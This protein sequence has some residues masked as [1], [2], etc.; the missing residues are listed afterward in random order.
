MQRDPK[1]LAKLLLSIGFVKDENRINSYSF[2][3]DVEAALDKPWLINRWVITSSHG[4]WE[5]EQIDICTA[6]ETL[7]NRL[8]QAFKAVYGPSTKLELIPALN[9]GV[10]VLVELLQTQP[11]Q[12]EFPNGTIGFHFNLTSEGDSLCLHFSKHFIIG[13]APPHFLVETSFIF[14]KCLNFTHEKITY[15]RG[16]F[17]SRVDFVDFLLHNIDRHDKLSKL[18]EQAVDL[19]NSLKEGIKTH[20]KSRFNGRHWQITATNLDSSLFEFDVPPIEIVESR[21]LGIKFHKIDG[22]ILNNKISE[23]KQLCHA[24]L[25]E[26]GDSL[27][28]LRR[29]SIIALAEEKPISESLLS[30]ML[31]IDSENLLFLSIA[32]YSAMKENR[33]K[34]QLKYL[35]K[36]G[37]LLN[38]ELTNFDELQ[39]MDMVLPELLGDGWAPVDL[40]TA[41]TCYQRVVQKRG[42]VPRVLRKLV[43]IA[44]ERQDINGEIQL[45]SRL[46]EVDT[47]K[48]L[49]AENYMRLANLY[50]SNDIRLAAENALSAW[51]LDP[52]N[53]NYAEFAA[54]GLVQSK[55]F[56][57]AVR[58]LDDCRKF[59]D[60]V[61]DNQ[62]KINLELAI[63]RIWFTF[64]K[65][66]DLA[67][68]RIEHA[69]LLMPDDLENLKRCEDISLEFGEESLL[70][71][72]RQRIFHQALR[73]RNKTEVFRVVDHLLKHYKTQ[74]NMDAQIVKIYEK[75]IQHYL[76]SHEEL[77][78]L[79]SLKKV[80]I[81][82]TRLVENI[83]NHVDAEKDI[84]KQPYLIFV[85]EVSQLKLENK[86]LAAE[87]FE[88]A[89]DLGKIEP[90]IYEFLNEYYA[91]INKP[92]LRDKVLKHQL[93]N[94][95]S[96][97]RV[98]ILKDLFYTSKSLS[99]RELDSY[100]TM[101]LKEGKE[102]AALKKRFITYQ[103]RADVK[104][105]DRLYNE[106]L[107]EISERVEQFKWMLYTQSIL[108][109]CDSKDRFE[110][111]E[112]VLQKMKPHYK[113]IFEWYEAG[114]K[115]HQ[116][117]PDYKYLEPYL[118]KLILNGIPPKID[119]HITLKVL[120]SNPIAKGL[121][122]RY[123]ADQEKDF[124]RIAENL[125]NSLQ[126]LA[127]KAGY[128]HT[129]ENILEQLSGMVVL[130]KNELETYRQLTEKSEKIEN[131]YKV[132]GSQLE[133]VINS[134]Q[135]NQL[136]DLS[137]EII[138]DNPLVKL[139]FAK[140]MLKCIEAFEP[141]NI[142][143]FRFLLLE[144]NSEYRSFMPEVWGKM[145]LRDLNNWKND[146]RYTMILDWI[147]EDPRNRDTISS[148]FKENMIKLRTKRDCEQLD[149]YSLLARTYG[150]S[151]NTYNWFLFQHF[152][153]VPEPEKSSYYWVEYLRNIKEISSW[154]KFW[155]DS[156]DLLGA[157]SDELYH[158][159]RIAY[160][161][162]IQTAHP[163]VYDEL[164]FEYGNFLFLN[165]K[166]PELAFKL[167]NER[168]T[169]KPDDY[170]TWL[171]L[172]FL[173]SILRHSKEQYEL[174]RFILPKIDDHP[175]LIGNYPIT[176]ESLYKD[177]VNVAKQLK[178]SAEI[179]SF[180][181]DPSKPK[182]PNIKKSEFGH[183]K[184]E[185]TTTKYL[186]DEQESRDKDP[187]TAGKPVNLG[188]LFA[189]SAIELSRDKQKEP[190]PL[191]KSVVS[192]VN[193]D[194]GS[195]DKVNHEQADKV[196]PPVQKVD[197]TKPA[198]P[199]T[200]TES[201]VILNHPETP[202]AIPKLDT[203]GV[204][205][206]TEISPPRATLPDDP[207]KIP[208][209]K[210]GKK[211]KKS[212]LN[213]KKARWPFG[214]KAPETPPS[215]KSVPKTPSSQGRMTESTA[216]SLAGQ[217]TTA[218]WRN[219]LLASKGEKLIPKIQGMG[220]A[221]RVEKY[222][223]LQA[224]SLHDG[225]T[226]E[227]LDHF[228]W[229]DFVE[230]WDGQWSNIKLD[231][232]DSDI[233]R[234]LGASRD[235]LSEFY[236]EKYNLRTI[237]RVFG[238]SIDK[239]LAS[240]TT[241]KF[242]DLFS[243]P[244]AENYQKFLQDMDV[245]IVFVDGPEK[246][247]YEARKGKLYVGQSLAMSPNP[248][249]LHHILYI[250][251]SVQLGLFE[252][253]M[254]KERLKDPLITFLKSSRF[255]LQEKKVIDKAIAEFEKPG[256]FTELVQR[257]REQVLNILLLETKNLID[258]AQFE[259][260][261]DG[262]GEGV[263]SVQVR[264]YLSLIVKMF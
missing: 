262:V 146:Q 188:S 241:A 39:T 230:P 168:Y 60:S 58:V 263:S 214:S 44:R 43:S 91:S 45:L 258:L 212:F 259:A 247:L 122:Y 42:D 6:I 9:Y 92:D 89:V 197:P 255:E 243:W 178:K 231:I 141:Q 111:I 68:L 198:A 166:E 118:N 144:I 207:D 67:K 260:K 61:A 47:D 115:S 113:D 51:K 228:N 239:F 70:V 220:F 169:R 71:D 100:G 114:V 170:H 171:P 163:M 52:T 74:A 191:P 41:Q 93:R 136:K 165:D 189:N 145:Y 37:Q 104:S 27:F 190:R 1:N 233:Y 35:S 186:G 210:V 140:N 62:K 185:A 245:E 23:A 46:V 48:N 7:G 10:W 246:V 124:D 79:L 5:T 143:E 76:I 223:A 199:P 26:E 97:Q 19:G 66:K 33:T 4:K 224:A 219:C 222:L 152:H 237:S 226:A 132:I 56:E 102:D 225:E 203:Q 208:T 75:L 31:S 134:D 17:E 139:D 234:A 81:D 8:D 94:A 82:W 78:G 196:P 54:Y 257:S 175:E 55:D 21:E 195:Q 123:L 254:L 87:Y 213:L 49:V 103:E 95:N 236:Q 202:P 36:M 157:D 15:K 261:M 107:N 85:G 240:R 135:F 235:F 154:K 63:A 153:T 229:L 176:T 227:V 164:C 77:Y 40:Q 105:I 133:H 130:Q 142:V 187:K 50:Q 125:R 205:E 32:S 18:R 147:L 98:P 25:E 217:Q 84:D 173:N 80:S 138:R 22:L 206:N 128:E 121:Y 215:P 53:T 73:I 129:T 252:V 160:R 99:D 131:F 16:I 242:T 204:R 251:R 110:L 194:R 183:T 24:A 38:E 127:G 221:N 209:V 172:Y 137:F 148:I 256:C 30:R 159:L 83:E 250:I 69:L 101:I 264:K 181:F 150:F 155:Q 88:K 126:H 216:Q 3:N 244:W 14:L 13:Y 167:L 112:K 12:G 20:L 29:I 193:D 108:E 182:Q 158:L 177:F 211:E 65:R 218:E 120:K 109:D 11:K 72:I 119:R 59:I 192:V 174:L 2:Q 238:L 162:L 64:L 96:D 34:N 151:F 106:V 180:L 184:M 201:T 161:E 86:T 200:P 248:D 156:V 179:D 253:I 116:K 57:K 28:L 149:A 90:R 232:F 117:D 249:L